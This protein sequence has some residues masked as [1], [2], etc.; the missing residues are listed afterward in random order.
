MTKVNNDCLILAISLLFLADHF[1]ID[2]FFYEKELINS[3]EFD[4]LS[5]NK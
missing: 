1:Q 4:I 2:N 3:L 5:I